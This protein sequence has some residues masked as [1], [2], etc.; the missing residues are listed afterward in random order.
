M[1]DP[2][3]DTPTTGSPLLDLPGAVAGEG[4]DAAVAA[5]YGSFNAEQRTLEAGDGFVDLSHRGVLRVTGPDR[6][7]YLHSLTTQHLERLAPGTPVQALLLSPQGH[8]EHHLVGTDDGETFLAHTEPGRVQ[9]LVGFLDRMRFL[10]RV[11]VEDVTASYAVAW[12]PAGAA[13]P[14]RYDVFD[15]SRLRQYA[16]AAG[17]ACGLWAYD[18]LRIARGEPRLGVDTDHRTIPNE[19]GWIGPAVHLDKGCYRGQETVARVHTLG[20]PPRRLTMLHLDGSEN[21]LPPA[22]TPI[23]LAGR[24]VGFVGSAARHHELGPIALGL[25]KRNVPVAAVLEVAGMPAAQEVVVD[26]EVGLHARPRLG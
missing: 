9:E 3:P 18:A 10:M 22:G 16:E 17:P 11:E 12:R 13:A 23:T 14:G 20:R 26:P 8:V 24:P 21:R 15:R 19:V 4:I 25:L 2:T 7:T 6:L 5:H 1:T